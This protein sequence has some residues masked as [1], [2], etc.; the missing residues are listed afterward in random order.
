MRVL[1]NDEVFAE[2][3]K[4]QRHTLAFDVKKKK[5]KNPSA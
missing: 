2:I 5:L 4:W 1:I 3:S